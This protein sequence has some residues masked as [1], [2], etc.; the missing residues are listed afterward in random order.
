MF[1]TGDAGLFGVT[2][3]LDIRTSPINR[4]LK[5]QVDEGQKEA[6]KKELHCD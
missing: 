5:Q 6:R 3:T 4:M 2:L 1:I